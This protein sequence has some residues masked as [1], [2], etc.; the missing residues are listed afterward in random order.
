ML[1]LWHK[2][3]H[4]ILRMRASGVQTLQK[5]KKLCNGLISDNWAG[6]SGQWGG[7]GGAHGLPRTHRKET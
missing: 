2:L 4:V 7:V 6:D 1:N 5:G 3:E